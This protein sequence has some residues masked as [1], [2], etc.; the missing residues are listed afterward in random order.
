MNPESFRG[1]N[2]PNSGTESGT[3][4]TAAFGHEARPGDD[5]EILTCVVHEQ[6]MGCGQTDDKALPFA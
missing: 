3:A 6:S 5:R 1:L 2:Q 4:P